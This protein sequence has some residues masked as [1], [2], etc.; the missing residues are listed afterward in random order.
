MSKARSQRAVTAGTA[1]FGKALV[2]E[3]VGRPLSTACDSEE[4]LSAAVQWIDALIALEERGIVHGDISYHILLLPS[5]PGD[6]ATILDL[7]L[8]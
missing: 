6:R 3:R 7:D 8:T 4:V 1:G 2:T 5:S